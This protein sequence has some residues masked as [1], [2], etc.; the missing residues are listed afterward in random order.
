[1]FRYLV[2][3]MR[4][5]CT[6]DDLLLLVSHSVLQTL[7]GLAGERRCVYVH[8]NHELLLIENVINCYKLTLCEVVLH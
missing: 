7:V 2:S 1:M 8:F 5:I 6:R 3:R 4:I